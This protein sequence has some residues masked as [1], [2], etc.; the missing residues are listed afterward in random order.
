[1][2]PDDIDGVLALQE[3]NLH[4]NLDE[5]QRKDGFLSA[6]FSGEQFQAMG[7]EVAVIVARDGADIAGYACG[8]SLAFNRQFPLLAAMLER[9]PKLDFLGRRLNA[10]RTFI[11]GPVCVHR[12]HRGKGVLRGMY[13]TFRRE[14][15]GDYDAGVLFIAKGNERSLNAHAHGLG[16]SIVGEFD[17]EQ[18]A[19]W[20][21]AFPVPAAPF[22]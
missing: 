9:W 22:C 13:D 6:R 7:R 15:A 4:A 12:E 16:M 21:L 8:S 5:A 10:Q 20:I 17:F 19:Y 18:R 11:Y 1:M 14:I 2:L 3:A